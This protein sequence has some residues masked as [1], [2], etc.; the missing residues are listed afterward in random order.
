MAAPLTEFATS[1][2][3]STPYLILM[4]V[5]AIW[6]GIWK[7]IAMWKAA[8]KRKVAWFVVLALFNTAGI[9]PIL[10]VY[11][12]SKMKL[13]SKKAG[14]KKEKTSKANERTNRTRKTSKKNTKKLP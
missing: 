11:V 14:N 8:T 7:L 1:L 10:Y 13:D 4:I 9:L 5:V 2:G 3:V 6:D 12:F